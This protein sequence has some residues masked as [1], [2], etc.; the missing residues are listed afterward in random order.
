MNRRN[1]LKLI[2]AAGA[3]SLAPLVPS[4][5]SEEIGEVLMGEIIN[6]R[7]YP[8]RIYMTAPTEEITEDTVLTISL[9]TLFKRA[10]PIL[11]NH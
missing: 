8:F 2:I 5:T 7:G 10:Y 9:D 1:F 4:H 11:M 6:I 3:V